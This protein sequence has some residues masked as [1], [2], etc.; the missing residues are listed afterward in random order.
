MKV[1]LI[2]RQRER[3]IPFNLQEENQCV[4]SDLSCI[5]VQCLI[6][7]R[8]E[9]NKRERKKR[10]NQRRKRESDFGE[11]RD[12]MSGAHEILKNP[13]HSIRR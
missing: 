12:T 11:E 6:K 10:E 2:K 5:V 8:E 1:K 3:E 4:T 7:E 13:I 9:M